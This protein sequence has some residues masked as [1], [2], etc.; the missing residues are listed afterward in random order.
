MDTAHWLTHS[1]FILDLIIRVGLSLRVIKR[2]LPVGVSLAWLA[3]I[4]IFPFVGAVIYLLVG[5][6]RLGRHRARRA[7]D[8]RQVQRAEVSGARVAHRADPATVGAGGA[9]VARLAESVLG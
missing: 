2:R 6:Y 5:E 7:A 4:L 9:A 3:I 1:I 8:Y